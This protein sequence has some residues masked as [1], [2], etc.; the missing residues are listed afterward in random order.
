MNEDKRK[1]EIIYTRDRKDRTQN[2][3]I[4]V[5]DKEELNGTIYRGGELVMNPK[6]LLEE[7]QKLYDVGTFHSMSG[8]NIRDEIKYRLALLLLNEVLKD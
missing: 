6:I 5:D 1:V 8:K 7:I 3:V 4:K 2:V